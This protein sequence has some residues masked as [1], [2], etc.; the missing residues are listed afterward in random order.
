MR[1]LFDDGDFAPGRVPSLVFV[2]AQR[3]RLRAAIATA[4]TTFDAGR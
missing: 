4:Q 2:M 3:E 1:A